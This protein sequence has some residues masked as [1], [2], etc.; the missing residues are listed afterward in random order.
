MLES[1]QRQVDHSLHIRA[2]HREPRIIEGEFET[3]QSRYNCQ[4]KARRYEHLSHRQQAQLTRSIWSNQ[5]SRKSKTGGWPADLQHGTVPCP[6][7]LAPMHAATP[8][9]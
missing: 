1:G 8:V 5:K 2:H 6:L 4:I 9:H 3:F 7:R